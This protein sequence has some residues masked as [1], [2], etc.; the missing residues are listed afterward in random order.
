MPSAQGFT[1][2]IGTIP[3]SEWE[4]SFHAD[5]EFG[6]IGQFEQVIEAIRP[7]TAIHFF[8]LAF[9]RHPLVCRGAHGTNRR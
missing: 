1:N 3:G 4:Y 9:T 2:V 7:I 6:S 8:A 5:M